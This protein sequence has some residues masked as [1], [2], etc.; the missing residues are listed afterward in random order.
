[1]EPAVFSMRVPYT[2]ASGQTAEANV[3]LVDIP[4]GTL[5]FRGIRLPD[6]SNGEDSRIFLRDFLGDPHG[7]HFCLSPTH[8]VFFYPFPHVPFGAH[9]VGNRFNAVMI[10]QTSR[11]LRV[12]CM[13]NPSKWIR[14]GEIKRFD[15]TAPIQRCNKLPFTCFQDKDMSEEQR[16]K[17]EEMKSWDNCI[18]PEW[19]M[20]SGVAGWMAIADYDSIDNFNV[21]GTAPKDTSM[22]RYLLELEQHIPGKTADIL[23]DM[24]SDNRRHRG[25][26]EIALFPWSPHPG[27]D[28]QLTDASDA[29]EATNAISQL[30]DIFNYLPIAC[31][32]TEGIMEAFSGDFQVA[33]LPVGSTSVTASEDARARIDTNMDTYMKKLMT[34]G[35]RIPDLG[36]AKVLF[37]TRTGFYV[38]D[39]F[40]P[41]DIYF[42]QGEKDIAYSDLLLPLETELDKTRVLEYK[43]LFRSYFP[44]KFLQTLAFEDGKVMNRAFIFERP[45][46]LRTIFKDLHLDMPFFMTRFLRRAASIF[47]INTS[48]NHEGGGQKRKTRRLHLHRGG[49][50]DNESM[51]PVEIE[52]K[53][54]SISRNTEE[55]LQTFIGNAYKQLWSSWIQKKG[56]VEEE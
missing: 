39:L 21:R 26:P 40:A 2:K 14:G 4:S 3:P 6:V 42:R 46:L 45:P 54:E 24:Y 38:F 5:L 29:E 37:D 33:D 27:P 25:I 44:R 47:R 19:A 30:S 7:D 52:A 43:I 10:Y 41:Q 16:I 23:L 32:T 34:E 48:G 13:I 17:E 15:G 1:M 31:I 56:L 20:E 51:H 55:S 9:T 12:A 8:N 53:A 28:V 36:T 35:V 11:N 22:G 18:R 49:E 50:E